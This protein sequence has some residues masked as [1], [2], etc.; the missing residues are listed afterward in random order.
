MSHENLPTSTSLRE[1]IF[2]FLDTFTVIQ[3]EIWSVM[4]CASW[5]LVSVGI[6]KDVAC[7]ENTKVEKGENY[8][9]KSM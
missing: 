5:L 2:N 7:S 8:I 6:L 1:N 3:K 4:I 9:P